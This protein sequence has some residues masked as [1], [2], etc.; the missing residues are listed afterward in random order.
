LTFQRVLSFYGLSY[1]TLAAGGSEV[2][3]GSYT[4]ILEAFRGGRVDHLFGATAAPADVIADIGAAGRGARLAPLPSDLVTHLASASYRPGVIR[5]GTYPSMQE[6]DVP[7]VYMRTTF[8]T[9]IAVPDDVVEA[10]TSTLLA[11]LGDLP[12]IHPSLAAFEP[13]AAGASLPVPLHPGAERAYR[14]HN[15]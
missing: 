13:A 2:F 9:S 5:R 15:G 4:D 6:A 7:T 14:H 8:L 11:N 1:A 12:A 10:V 3:H